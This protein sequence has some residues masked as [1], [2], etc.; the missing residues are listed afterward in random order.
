MYDVVGHIDNQNPSISYYMLLSTYGD[1]SN[2]ICA[3]LPTHFYPQICYQ[4]IPKHLHLHV[5]IPHLPPFSYHLRN[6]LP[7]YH[8]Q[9]MKA[10]L[11]VYDTIEAFSHDF[12]VFP[13]RLT[14]M[15]VAESITSNPIDTFTKLKDCARQGVDLLPASIAAEYSK[16]KS[17]ARSMQATRAAVRVFSIL[18]LSASQRGITT[19]KQSA[20]ESWMRNRCSQYDK[21]AKSIRL[22]HGC[23]P[24][25]LKSLPGIAITYLRCAVKVAQR[26][27]RQATANLEGKDFLKIFTNY[28]LGEI[29]LEL[30]RLC[31]KLEQYFTSLKR[32]VEANCVIPETEPSE[33]EAAERL[34]FNNTLKDCRALVQKFNKTMPILY[35]VNKHWKEEVG[36]LWS[37][38]VD[39]GDTW[40]LQNI[41]ISQIETGAYFEEC[42]KDSTKEMIMN[43]TRLHE[44]ATESN[45]LHKEIARTQTSIIASS[46][47]ACEV[48]AQIKHPQLNA[49]GYTNQVS[50]KTQS[51]GKHSEQ[52]PFIRNNHFQADLFCTWN[53]ILAADNHLEAD[54]VDLALETRSLQ[55]QL[56][57][58]WYEDLILLVVVPDFVMNCIWSQGSRNLTNAASR[59]IRRFV[60]KTSLT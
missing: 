51:T 37:D 25:W 6:L 57:D 3:G 31:D 48:I 17:S 30:D 35:V 18:D 32:F 50:N 59:I 8:F 22:L 13:M 5:S 46:N 21:N 26:R 39:K 42:T 34:A 4:Y 24:V 47:L 29:T 20:N 16:M 55:M 23:L 11:L 15:S 40:S 41:D 2:S 56:A 27:F 7:N 14:F 53:Y 44:V 9:I 10:D 43:I 1:Y 45:E 60:E 19:S 36:R 38:E 28:E 58:Q 49:F 52:S 54:L 33:E 12:E